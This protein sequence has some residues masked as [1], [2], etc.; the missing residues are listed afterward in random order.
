MSKRISVKGRGLGAY[1]PNSDELSQ[2][3]SESGEPVND[4]TFENPKASDVD[5]SI[6]SE[7]RSTQQSTTDK[8]II[9]EL[10]AR[11]GEQPYINAAFRF[12]RPELD[13]LENVVHGLKIDYGIKVTKQDIIRVGLA[14]LI[15]EHRRKGSKSTLTRWA[16]LARK[17]AS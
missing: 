3:S 8:S 10:I 17:L 12:S 5:L 15:E 14:A 2:H 13:E 16:K 7:Y 4:T 9:D 11:L 6:G 1:F